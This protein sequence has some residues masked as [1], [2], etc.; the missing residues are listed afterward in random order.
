MISMKQKKI[1][2]DW[3]AGGSGFFGLRYMLGD[4][5]LEGYLP[6]NPETLSQRT[7]REVNGIL[8]LLKPKENA[9]I[10]DVPSGYGRHSIAL[11]RKG[12]RVTGMDINDELIEHAKKAARESELSISFRKRDMRDI[13]RKDYGSYDVVINMFYSFG[14]FMDE[15]DNRKAMEQFFR[16]LRPKGRLLLHTDVSPEILRNKKAY[17][18][19][20]RQLKRGRKLVI[21][22]GF[23]PTTARMEGSWEITNSFGAVVAPRA[24]YSV[25]IYTAWELMDMARNAGFKDVKIFGSFEGSEFSEESSELIMVAGKG[26]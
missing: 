11:A 17:T 7:D 1:V 23:N 13:G 20:I 22:E 8:R 15:K 12:F 6:G 16:A 5:S 4:N 25:R 9:R 18:D 21:I 3:W 24:Y 19:Q 10:L 26:G 14:F 2:D